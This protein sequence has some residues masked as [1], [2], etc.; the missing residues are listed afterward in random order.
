M[1]TGYMYNDVTVLMLGKIS[2]IKSVL[3]TPD[4]LDRQKYTYFNTVQSNCIISQYNTQIFHRYLCSISFQKYERCTYNC[5]EIIH[6]I[7]CKEIK[8]YLRYNANRDEP[9]VFIFY[10]LAFQHMFSKWPLYS[11]PI[12]QALQI[13]QREKCRFQQT[14]DLQF[15]GVVEQR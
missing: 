12:F 11:N 7:S 14:W 6:Y 3:L 4:I 8:M 9:F 5:I 15:L 1:A 2:K 10:Y 13:K